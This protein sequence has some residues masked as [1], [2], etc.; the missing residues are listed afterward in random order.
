SVIIYMTF[1]LKRR[2]SIKR[3]FGL[4]PCI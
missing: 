4:N 1:C 2:L 3:P